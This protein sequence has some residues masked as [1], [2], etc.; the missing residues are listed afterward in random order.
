ML[1]K[2]IE[3]IIGNDLGFVPETPA[4]PYGKSGSEKSEQTLLDMA[5]KMDFDFDKKVLAV[6]E[7]NN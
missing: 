3:L 4:T 6:N 2:D 1:V 7:T 5:N